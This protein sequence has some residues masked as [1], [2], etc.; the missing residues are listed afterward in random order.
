MNAE[1][2]DEFEIGVDFGIDGSYKLNS[3]VPLQVR[4]ISLEKDF[5]GTLRVQYHMNYK[6]D[7]AL[8]KSVNLSKGEEGVVNYTLVNIPENITS[9]KS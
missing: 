8:E 2:T 6:N 1:T 5:S 4:L 3:N 9:F 7:I